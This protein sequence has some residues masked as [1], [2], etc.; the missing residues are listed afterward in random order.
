MRCP[1]LREAQV[2]F[3]RASV[4]KKM[5]VRL[6]DQPGNERCSSKEYVN[7]PAAKQYI[8]DMPSIDHCPFLHESLVQYCTASAVTKYIPYSESVNSQCGT[9]SHRYCDLYL[10]IAH[11][12]M[13]HGPILNSDNT[14]TRSGKEYLVDNIRVPEN[15]WFSPNHM[16]MEISTEGII[17]IGIDEFMVKLLGHIESLAFVT[18]TGIQ[19][20]TVVLTVHGFDMNLTFPYHVHITKANTYL[21]SNPQKILADPYHLGWLFEG[22]VEKS[23][24]IKEAFGGLIQGTEAVNWIDDELKRINSFTHELSSR[25]DM[26]GAVLMADGGSVQTGI[27]YLLQRDDF[28]QLCNQFFTLFPSRKLSP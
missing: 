21:R 24:H 10:A 9:D 14:I 5:I 22:I 15:L 1:F 4:Y 3:C 7:C 28:L 26:Q 23:V 12:E 18:T 19:R 16:W 6:P 17:H 25:P 2:K 20:P 8:E 13:Q 27:S 11:P